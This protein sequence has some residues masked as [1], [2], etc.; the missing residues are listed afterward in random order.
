M[1]RKRPCFRVSDPWLGMIIAI[2]LA[3]PSRAL[4]GADNS[5]PTNITYI[6]PATGPI[7]YENTRLWGT[8]LRHYY[9][10]TDQ[11]GNETTNEFGDEITYAP[12]GRDGQ[13]TLGMV[14]F[15]YWLSRLAS[16]K[17]TLR[18]R[19]YDNSGPK[20][21][22]GHAV[23]GLL[24]YD[25]GVIATTNYTGYQ[26]LMLKGLNLRNVPDSVT[27]TVQFE[28]LSAGTNGGILCYG[29][30]TTGQSFDDFW[31]KQNG[32]WGTKRFTHGGAWLADLGFR[33]SAVSEEG[34]PTVVRIP[35]HMEFDLGFP[36][37]PLGVEVQAGFDSSR[38]GLFR[39]LTLDVNASEYGQISMGPSVNS[40]YPDGTLISLGPSA[41]EGW[42]FGS[43][44]GDVTGTNVPVTLLMDGDKHVTANFVVPPPPPVAHIRLEGETVLI[45]WTGSGVLQYAPAITGPWSD[46]GSADSPFSTAMSSATRF[47]RVR[48]EH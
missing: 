29:P 38:D 44:S 20:D 40:L 42:I 43:W 13:R 18:F 45:E 6:V 27:W 17:E 30:P 32:V 25:S 19:L 11:L 26:T 12:T 24:L 33:A 3:N 10:P 8:E 16:G 9:F 4:L 21:A 39:R 7:I 48:T 2:L 34:S 14:Q 41:A 28:G 46:T 22:N 31:E 37:P 15:E 23:P 47:Y 36:V 5:T 35:G 1:E